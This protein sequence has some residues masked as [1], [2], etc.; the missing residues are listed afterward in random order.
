M[1]AAVKSRPGAAP[2]RD[3]ANASAQLPE[4]AAHSSLAVQHVCVEDSIV[5]ARS[6]AAAI[7]RAL[8]FERALH[9]CQA[10][11]VVQLG[12]HVHGELCCSTVVEAIPRNMELIATAA[13]PAKRRRGKGKKTLASAAAEAA[14]APETV[15]AEPMTPPP[16]AK[17]SRKAPTASAR[18]NGAAKRQQQQRM[19]STSSVVPCSDEGV[20]LVDI[21]PEPDDVKVE[22]P[23]PEVARAAKR[24]K[25][26]HTVAEI[27]EDYVPRD[28]PG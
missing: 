23:S 4:V 1:V 25:H 20:E 9:Q 2:R 13:P 28:L 5:A 19:A 21:K 18:A 16:K 12:P 27:A 26:R 24:P 22:P 7:Q 15:A 3:G 14:V 17:A 8:Q 10:P 11:P 6:V